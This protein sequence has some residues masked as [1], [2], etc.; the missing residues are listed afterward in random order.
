MALLSPE[1]PLAVRPLALWSRP[2]VRM[3]AVLSG[4]CSSGHASPCPLAGVEAPVGTVSDLRLVEE[5]GRRVR[6]SWSAVPG[7]TEYKVVVRNNQ[8]ESVGRGAGSAW[9]TPAGWC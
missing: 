3:G 4:L 7:A 6:L 5:A 9:G 1:T 2:R 8:G